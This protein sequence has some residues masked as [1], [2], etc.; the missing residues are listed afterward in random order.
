MFDDVCYCVYVRKREDSQCNM[1]HWIPFEGMLMEVNS[2]VSLLGR[3]FRGIF[4]DLC[5]SVGGLLQGC[6]RVAIWLHLYKLI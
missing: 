2:S 5:V 1:Q 6:N 4:E 3:G